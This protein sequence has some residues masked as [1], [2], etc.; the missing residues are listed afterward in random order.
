MKS[1]IYILT[2]MGDNNTELKNQLVIIEKFL[3]KLQSLYESD[4]E[5]KKNVIGK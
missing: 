2:S 5:I 3:N 4:L 1:S